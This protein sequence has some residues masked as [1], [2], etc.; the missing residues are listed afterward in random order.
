MLRQER[1]LPSQFQDAL[2]SGGLSFVRA[3]LQAG[4]EP[5][6]PQR[7]HEAQSGGRGSVHAVLR[8][9]ITFKTNDILCGRRE[10]CP[11]NSIT[12]YDRE[13]SALYVPRYRRV[14]SPALP[15]DVNTKHDHPSLNTTLFWSIP[16][17]VGREVV[18][19]PFVFAGVG[20]TI[21]VHIGRRILFF[22][23]NLVLRDDVVFSGQ[24][25]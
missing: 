10:S 14:R 6:P 8:I 2:R 18:V 7:K 5:R 9:A 24:K 11:P 22:R 16:L 15:P 23:R 19:R 3:S 13:G 12:N 17:R 25:L 21:Y 20:A 4:A 1:L